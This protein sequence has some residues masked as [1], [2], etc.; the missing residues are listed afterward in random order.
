ME[1]CS[2]GIYQGFEHVAT[3][4]QWKSKEK[5]WLSFVDGYH[6]DVGTKEKFLFELENE[7]GQNAVH[8]AHFLDEMAKLVPEGVSH[9]H[10]HLDG[11][12]EIDGGK[13]RMRFHDGAEALADAVIGCDGIKSRVRQLILGD[14]DPAAQPQYTH[15]YAYRGLIP[16]D[17]AIE[18]LGEEKAV[19]A[20]LHVRDVPSPPIR[21]V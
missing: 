5:V 3:K 11:V 6:H 2:N 9:F 8:R 19:N 17:K 13:L 14:D 18:A 15:K 1:L 10:K 20:N 4:S 7:L 21:C 12:T 16:M